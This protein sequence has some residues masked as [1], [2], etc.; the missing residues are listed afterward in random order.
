MNELIKKL[1]SLTELELPNGAT[2]A[3]WLEDVL[4]VIRKH[5]EEDGVE[6]YPY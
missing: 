2:G 3:V 6:R 1:R 4:A 5:Y